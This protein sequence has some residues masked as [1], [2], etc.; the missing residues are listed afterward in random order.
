MLNRT[1]PVR[2]FRVPETRPHGLVHEPAFR[3]LAKVFADRLRFPDGAELRRRGAP[4][5]AP[6]AATMVANL[7]PVALRGRYQAA[8]AMCWGVA[9]TV[10]PLAA[11][12]ALQRLGARTLWLLCLAV[13]AAVARG[14][15]LTAEPRRKRLAA[16]AR[17]EPEPPGPEATPS[18]AMGG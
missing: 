1:A 15:L 12:E 9:F 10:S 16:L 4:A 17:S 18:E 11:G 13:A 8:F 14:D 7:A 3:G 6:L 5:A 2:F